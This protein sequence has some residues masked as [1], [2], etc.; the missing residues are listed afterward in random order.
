MATYTKRILSGSTDGR[1]I[2]VA[3]TATPGT[4]LHTAVVGTTDFDEI[5]IWAVNSSTSAVKLTVEFGGTVAPDDQIEFSIPPE[6]GLYLVVPGLVLQNGAI[7]RAFAGTA[8][9]IVIYGY[10][11]RI[12]A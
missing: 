2:T 11:N 1:G 8:N 9:A 6:D 12:A 4:V 3:A 10:V 7:V 5:W